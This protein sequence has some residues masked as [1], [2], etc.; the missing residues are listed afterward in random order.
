MTNI[1]RELRTQRLLLRRWQPED[2]EAFA[3]MNADPHVMEFFPGRLSREATEERVDRIEAHFI[4][5]GFGLWAVEIVGITP[6]AGML[7]LAVPPFQTAFT[8]C[9]EVAWRLQREHWNRGYA[10]EGG[11]A[12]LEFGFGALGLKEV[13]SYTVPANL[14][15]RRVMEKIGMTHS[16]AEDFD[17]P[18]VPD[19]HPL[20]RHVLYRICR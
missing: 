19:G 1:P 2:R 6:F 8:P 5:H 16:P 12:A 13:L 15:S 7:G 20:K 9:V 14:A 3:T 17:H 10:T 11:T 4:E 18:L